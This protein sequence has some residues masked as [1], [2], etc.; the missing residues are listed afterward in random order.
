MQDTQNRVIN[1]QLPTFLIYSSR[2][3]NTFNVNVNIK[4]QSKVTFNLTYEE[5]LSRRLGRYEQVINISPEQVFLSR[6]RNLSCKAFP[7]SYIVTPLGN[8]CQGL[9]DPCQH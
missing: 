6:N 2:N 9:Q 7:H 4:A 8:F 5:L 1:M 3:S